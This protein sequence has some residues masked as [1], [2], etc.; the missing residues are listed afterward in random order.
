[1]PGT[2]PSLVYCQSVQARQ[3][4]GS[5]GRP[6]AYAA[7]HSGSAPKA[8]LPPVHARHQSAVV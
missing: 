1:M 6:V 3:P 4:A 8:V 7:T 2:V 5:G